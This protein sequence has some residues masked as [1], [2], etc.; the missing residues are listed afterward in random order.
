MCIFQVFFFFKTCHMEGTQL[1]GNHAPAA[2]LCDQERRYHIARTASEAV[3]VPYTS[4]KLSA[5]FTPAQ[6]SF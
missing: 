4:C 6:E 5:I 1:S 3:K 2:N